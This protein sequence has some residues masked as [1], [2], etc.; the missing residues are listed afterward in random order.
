MKPIVMPKTI[1][2]MQPT[3]CQYPFSSGEWLFEPKWDGYRA[4]CFLE[5]AKVRFVSRNQRSLSQRFPVL[6]EGVDEVKAENAI[7]DGEIVALDPQG[8][9]V[10]EGLRSGRKARGCVIVFQVFDLL[11]LDGQSLVDERL[12]VRKRKLKKVLKKG[13]RRRFCY[14]DHVLKQGERFFAELEKIGLEGMVAK[15]VDSVYVNGR[16]RDWLKIKTGIGKRDLRERGERWQ[17]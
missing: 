13:A 15:K 16:S 12:I 7:L 17:S 6:Q 14:T 5:N 10:F 8:M 3:V 1:Q 11:Y 4:I 9:P 2:P